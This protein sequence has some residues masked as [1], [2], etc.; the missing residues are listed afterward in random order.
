MTLPAR[1]EAPHWY[2]AVS[3]ALVTKIVKLLVVSPSTVLLVTTI[4][5]LL[6]VLVRIVLVPLS[7]LLHCMMG[8]GIPVDEHESVAGSGATTMVVFWAGSMET[9]G[10][11]T[12]RE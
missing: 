3:E 6:V 1:L 5:Y 7:I 9:T 4:W 11:S 2:V 12:Q 10:E 8:I